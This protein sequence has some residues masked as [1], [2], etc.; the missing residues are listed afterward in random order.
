MRFP[1][2]MILVAHDLS[3]ASRTAWRHAEALAESCG[4]AL[5]VVYV[6]PW[7]AA[8]D[9]LPPPD[10]IPSHVR[11][12]RAR[13][14]AAVG[15][16]PKISILQGDPA[17]RILNFARAQPPDLIVIGTHGRKG[18]QRAL[19]GSV[20]EAVIRGATVPVLAARG[21]V[22][23]IRAI[24]AP[25]NFTP[26]SDYGFAYAAAAA[27]ALPARLTALHLTGDPLWDGNSRYQLS[28]LI[29]RLPAEVRKNC[30]PLAQEFVG[31]PVKGILKASKGH[32]WIVLVAHRKSLIKDA[33]LGTTVERVLR[34]SSIPVLSVPAPGRAPF[35]LLSSGGAATA[36]RRSCP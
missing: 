6:D 31:E 11:S 27:A 34:R 32:D 33:F 17:G 19:L 3:D 16:G 4:A 25:V 12:L 30:R 8:V 26:Y 10:M 35:A 21:P 1:P 28:N 18:L 7:H 13:V 22:R 2:R 9:L 24:L 29:R 5:A 36:R 14:R 23:A 20:A 15:A